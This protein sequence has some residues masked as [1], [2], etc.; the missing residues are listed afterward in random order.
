MPQTY[1]RVFKKK[2]HNEI[3]TYLLLWKIKI[4]QNQMKIVFLYF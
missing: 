4:I 3:K 1:D 2:L